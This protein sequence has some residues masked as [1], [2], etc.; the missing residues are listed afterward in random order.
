MIADE[1]P[2]ARD[3]ERL[4]LLFVRAPQLG[5]VKTRLA[6]DL[7]PDAALQVHRELGAAAARAARGAA[8]RVRVAY[9][10]D[11]GESLVRAWLG[12]GAEMVAQGRGDLGARLDAATRDAFAAGAA[13]VVVVGGDCPALTSA[14]VDEAFDRLAHADVV[15]GPASDG[16]YYLIGMIR[17]SP[18]LFAGIPWSSTETCRAT[19]AAAAGAGR[20]VALLAEHFDVD[21]A[22]DWRRWREQASHDQ[23]PRPLA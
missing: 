1:S 13:R 14:V 7:G 18:E 6:A 12:D 16:G 5:L 20:R 8:C 19:L 2:P 11:D 10:P 23:A 17:P 15:V 4:L 22:A 9:T 3:Q 21:T